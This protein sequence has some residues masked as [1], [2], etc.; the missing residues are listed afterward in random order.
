MRRFSRKSRKSGGGRIWLAYLMVGT[1]W[2]GMSAAYKSKMPSNTEDICT[3]FEDRRDWYQAAR[4]SEERWGTPAHIQMAIVQQES[5]F[6]FDARPPRT[7]LL[8]FIPWKRQSNA[9]GFAQALDGTWARYQKDTGR[10]YA[11]RDDFEDA[12]DFIGWYTNLSHQS[13]GISKWDPYNQY[14]AYHEGQAGWR[15]GTYE[16]KGWLKKAAKR[17]DTRARQWG[18]QL[19]H[20][21]AGLDDPF[22]MFKG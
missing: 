18:A 17:V 5:S 11:D 13:E 15:R 2:F 3:V 16:K 8:G 12:I 7:S 19:K 9:Y 1:L 22:W 14:L 21:E 20:C 10:G 4:D 6:R